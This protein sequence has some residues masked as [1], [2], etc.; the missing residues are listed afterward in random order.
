MANKDCKI[1]QDLLPSYIDKLTSNETNDFIENHLM[2]C[3]TCKNVLKDM[4]ED[5]VLDKIEEK[6][7]INYL[8][9]IK[10]KQKITLLIVILILLVFD[11]FMATFFITRGGTGVYILNENG[12]PMYKEAFINWVTG[13]NKI[14]DSKNSYI[15]LRKKENINNYSTNQTCIFIFNERDVCT[16]YLIIVEGLSEEEL[17]EREEQWKKDEGNLSIM[18]KLKISNGI[19]YYNIQQFIGY[20]KNDP[21]LIEY[22][23]N[24]KDS[25]YIFEF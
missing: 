4:S 14:Y 12:R 2:N 23:D 25:Y 11:L 24:A 20:K 6:K 19:L 16:D 17:K 8:K 7:K 13:A 5:I 22:I 1:V 3:D 18:T 9:K 21:K 10:K 15:V